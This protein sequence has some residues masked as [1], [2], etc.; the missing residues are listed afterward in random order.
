MV[1]LYEILLLSVAKCRCTYSALI[2]VSEV[3]I[4]FCFVRGR[5][6]K[7]SV[8]SENWEDNWYLVPDEFSFFTKKEDVSK[9]LEKCPCM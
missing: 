7:C 8:L 1:D 4:M 9:Y 2:Y 5:G 6:I 3:C